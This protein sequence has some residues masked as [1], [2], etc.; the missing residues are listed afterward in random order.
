MAAAIELRRL[1]KVF[2]GVRALAGLD[3]DV[4]PGQLTGL[5]GPD[6]AGKTTL[7]RIMAALMSPTE[8]TVRVA[9]HDVVAEGS[10][11]HSIVGYMPPSCAAS[12]AKRRKAL[13]RS[14]CA[15]PA[16]RRSRR[17]WRAGFPAA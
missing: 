4:Q 17:A 3:A 14:S 16:S 8:G 15:S 5:V 7:M 6:G 1:A 13:S 11:I 10:R 9:G 2:D 12:I